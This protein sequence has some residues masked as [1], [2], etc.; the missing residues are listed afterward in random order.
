MFL[1]APPVAPFMP[2]PFE[3][4]PYVRNSDE[5]IDSAF[6]S[7]ANAAES[8]SGVDSQRAQTQRAASSLE[9][10]LTALVEGFP[11]FDRLDGLYRELAQVLVDVDDVRRALGRIDGVA[12]QVDEIARETQR[13]IADAEETQEA[14]DARRRA[15]ARMD[16]VV[17][18]LDDDLEML[19]EAREKLTDIPEIRDEPT[20]VIAGA[21]NVGK[22]TLLRGMT[23]AKPEVDDYAFTTQ[24]LEVGHLE[25]ERP[26]VRVQVVETPGLLDRDAEERNEMER[27]AEI[28]LDQ[29]ADVVV[30]IYDPSETCGYSMETQKKLRRD[31]VPEDLTVLEVGN[32]SDLGDRNGELDAEIS[33]EDP[34]DVERLS[35]EVLGLVD[36]E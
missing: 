8:S 34:E 26:D 31:V 15:F 20:V 16:S 36:A 9:S 30:W 7:A 21:P 33:A 17:R 29:V 25:T 2:T 6:S 35:E 11:S 27:R 3:N 14:V 10:S 1:P 12:D 28:V 18:E 23:A 32:K 5:M 13:E 4:V 19:A 24:S 22:S